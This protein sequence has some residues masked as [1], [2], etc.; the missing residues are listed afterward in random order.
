MISPRSVFVSRHA[1]RRAAT[2]HREAL[3]RDGLHVAD[4]AVDD[5]GS[6]ICASI[7]LSHISSPKTALV[8]FPPVV[9]TT[10]S[11]GAARASALWTI[12]LSP[13]PADDGQGGSG[14]PPA[15]PR[16]Q[17]GVHEIEATHRISDVGAR[18]AVEARRIVAAGSRGP[19]GR[20]GIRVVPEPVRVSVAL[21]S[22]GIISGKGMPCRPALRENG[23]VWPIADETGHAQGDEPRHVVR[24]IDDPGVDR[25]LLSLDRSDEAPSEDLPAFDA[26]RHLKHL[27]RRAGGWQ[28]Q[29]WDRVKTPWTSDRDGKPSSP[30]RA[31]FASLRRGRSRLNPARMTRPSALRVRT[32]A[33]VRRASSTSSPLISTMTGRL[34]YRPSTSASLGTPRCSRPRPA[35]RSRK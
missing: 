11:P 29:K 24:V 34:A 10:M 31:R 14:G 35:S 7:A 17:T 22:L 21:A 4:R 25:S 9:T 28:R 23:E 19:A 8:T 2:E 16:P 6:W 18:Q 13:R 30:A 12:K 3:R 32:S 33:T 5:E 20:T 15:G 1:G 26:K 27:G